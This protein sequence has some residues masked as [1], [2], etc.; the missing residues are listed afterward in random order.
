MNNLAN[1]LPDLQPPMSLASFEAMRANNREK[2]VSSGYIE[3]GR[4][5]ED[6]P[7]GPGG[8]WFPTLSNQMRFGRGNND[9]DG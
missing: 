7:L 8:M 1:R 9:A 3:Q 4:Q 2:F 6:R 5:L